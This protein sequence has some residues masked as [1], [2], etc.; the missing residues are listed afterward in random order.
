LTKFFQASLFS[1]SGTSQPGRCIIEATFT[2]EIFKLTLSSN[3]PSSVTVDI[4]NWRCSINF[5][6]RVDDSDD[7]TSDDVRNID[8]DVRVG[9]NQEEEEEEKAGP[10]KNPK[11]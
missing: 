6:D 1:N 10:A 2:T 8:F 9:S 7:H 4:D 11:K 3:T 5:D